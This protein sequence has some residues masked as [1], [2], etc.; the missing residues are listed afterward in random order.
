MRAL[1]VLVSLV[2]VTPLVNGAEAKCVSTMFSDASTVVALGIFNFLI[3]EDFT[4]S[5]G[6]TSVV[7]VGFSSSFV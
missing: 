6:E 4:T 7:S 3:L 1:V 5:L 2:C